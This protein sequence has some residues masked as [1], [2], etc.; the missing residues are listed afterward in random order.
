MR[1]HYD[2]AIEAIDR[3]LTVAR[4]HNAG[5]SEEARLLT[6]LAQAR[7]GQGEGDLAR[8]AADEAVEVARRQGARVLACHALLVRARVRR[9]TTT[10]D[11]DLAGARADLDAATALARETGASTYEPF[12]LE[13]LGRLQGDD[14]RLRQALRLYTTIGAT[15]HARRLEAEL[16]ASEGAARP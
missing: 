3:G 9:V 4:E 2:E 15:G 1:D 13:E 10:G 11:D 8:A 5:L 16:D 12:I 6:R 14:G 7:L